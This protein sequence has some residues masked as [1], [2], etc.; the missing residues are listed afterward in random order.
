MNDFSYADVGAFLMAVGTVMKKR[1]LCAMA[2]L[3]GNSDDELKEIIIDQVGCTE[4][5]AQ[6]IIEMELS[7]AITFV[8]E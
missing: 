3:D 8:E 7:D 2:T 1:G 6:D 4:E 5:R